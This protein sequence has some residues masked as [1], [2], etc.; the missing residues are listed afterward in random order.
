MSSLRLLLSRG[1]NQEAEQLRQ[2]LG[3]PVLAAVL[4]HCSGAQGAWG[5]LVRVIN[6]GEGQGLG[7]AEQEGLRR[8]PN[9]AL[10][11][12]TSLLPCLISQ[13]L[14]QPDDCNCSGAQG[15]W[16]HLVSSIDLGEGREGGGIG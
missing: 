8:L 14:S 4:G 2:Q 9:M 16:S 5:H 15:A 1:H 10:L 11:S 3:D 13:P 7:P 12:G 6:R